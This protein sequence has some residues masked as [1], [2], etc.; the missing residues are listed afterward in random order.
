MNIFN[1][2]FAKIGHVTWTKNAV[3]PRQH[4]GRIRNPVNIIRLQPVKIETVIATIK[5]LLYI[6]A[7]GADGIFFSLYQ[8][9]STCNSVLSVMINTSIVT[10]AFTKFWEHSITMTKLMIIIILYSLY[11]IKFSKKNNRRPSYISQDKWPTIQ[12]TCIQ[13]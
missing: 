11:C 1:N 4:T 13:K 9:L 2:F 12:T 7:V 6:D 5:H 8:R 3:A 10:D